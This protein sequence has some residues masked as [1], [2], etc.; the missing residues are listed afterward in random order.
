MEID[1]E[2]LKILLV[3]GSHCVQNEHIII[4]YD[5]TSTM[6]FMHKLFTELDEIPSN[7]IILSFSD[8]PEYSYIDNESFRIFQKLDC[9]FHVD[10]D[11]KQY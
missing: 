2:N 11:G 1:H 6:C 8:P 3:T 9:K 4:D 10:F 7:N 5:D